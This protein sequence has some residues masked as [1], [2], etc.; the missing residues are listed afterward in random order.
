MARVDAQDRYINRLYLT[1]HIVGVID[2][3]ASEPHSCTT[4]R[5]LPYLREA[6]YGNTVQLRNFVFDKS[7]ITTFVERWRPETQTF[8][9]PWDECTITLQ[10]V[11]YY[12]GLRTHGESVSSCLVVGCVKEGVILHQADMASGTSLAYARY[13][14]CNHPPYT[15]CYILLLIGGYLMTDKSNNHIHIRWLPLLDDFERCRILSWGSV[16][17]AWTYH[18]KEILLPFACNVHGT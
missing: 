3:E 18:S 16:V 13:Y 11:A 17:L 2:F 9:L 10:D 1:W 15:R 6:S 8:H 4:G 14:R 7:L 5:I 12:L